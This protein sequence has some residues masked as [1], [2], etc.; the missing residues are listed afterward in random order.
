MRKIRRM[1]NKNAQSSKQSSEE[2]PE[3]DSSSPVMSATGAPVTTTTT[4]NHVVNPNPSAGCVTNSSA[5]SGRHLPIISTQGPGSISNTT[6][7]HNMTPVDL[8]PI[9]NEL[10]EHRTENMRLHEEIESLKSQF[11][12]ECGLLNQTLNEERYRFE[13]SNFSLSLYVQMMNSIV[14]MDNIFSSFLMVT[15]N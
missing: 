15:A 9:L 3:G 6:D 7:P 4:G 5:G 14:L 11:N 10:K 12:S 1:F 8:E 2:E 13:V